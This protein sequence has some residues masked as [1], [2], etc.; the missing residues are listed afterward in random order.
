MTM[1]IPVTVVILT[2]NGL[3]Y[4][5]RCL[6]S[7]RASTDH[8]DYRVVVV[9]NAS[10]DG[11]VEYLQSQTWIT[12]IR[13]SANLG[14][15]KGNNIAIQKLDP[16]QDVVLL[17]NDTEIHRADWLSNLQTSAYR[18]EDIGIVG[19]R[20]VGPMESCAMPGLTCPWTPSGGSR[21]APGRWRSISTARTAMW[22]ASFLPAPT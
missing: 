10:T 12:L 18:A 19:C 4:T 6:E 8:P 13:N 22:R 11:T 20:L 14:F 16:A 15:A 5:R 2:W 3:A 21:S 17:N 7:L 9:D 1:P